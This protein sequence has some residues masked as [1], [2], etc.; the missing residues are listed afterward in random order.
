MPTTSPFANLARHLSA[1]KLSASAIDRNLKNRTTSN[2]NR[3]YTTYD[4]PKPA[5]ASAPAPGA[6]ASVV[7]PIYASAFVAPVPES[8]NDGH[9]EQKPVVAEAQVAKNPVNAFEG[10]GRT[11]TPNPMKAYARQPQA[12]TDALAAQ[13]KLIAL[14]EAAKKAAS[15]PSTQPVAG[16]VVKRGMFSIPAN[17]DDNDFTDDGPYDSDD[18]VS[19]PSSASIII[20]GSAKKFDYT[21]EQSAV[22]ECD[23]RLIVVDALAG[24]GKTTTAEGYA[25]AR[26]KERILYM[27]LNA[28]NAKEARSRFGSHVTVAT[29]HSVAWRAM[30]PKKERI[31]RNWKPIVLMDQLNLNTP[32]QGMITMR[33]LAD[34]FNSDDTYIS[35]KHA[36][37]VAYERDLRESDINNGIAHASLAWKRMCDPSDKMQMPDDAYLKMFALKAPKLN[38]DTIIF[39]EAQDANPV[40]LQI[41]K[42]QPHSKLLCIGDRHQSIYQFRGAVNAIEELSL[43]ST[44]LYLSNTWRFGP[45]VA[46]M[47]NL[48]LGELKNEKVKIKGMGTD[49][50][51]NGNHIT[52]LSRTNAEL[53]RLAAPIHGE[54]VHWVGGVDSYKMEQ[55][56]DAYHLFIREKD[57]IK[58]QLMRRKFNSWDEYSR[59]A[60]DANDGEAK[61]LVKVV[62][63]FTTDIPQVIADIR[64]NAVP[65]S[66]DASLTLTTAHRAKGM[67][68]DCV[69]ICND[70]ELLEESE[71][72]LAD[73]KNTAADLPIQDINLLY[74]AVTRACKSIELN[75]E[76]TKWIADLPRHRAN[77]E[78]AATRQ[79]GAVN[80]QVENM[81]RAE[82]M[83]IPEQ[84]RAERDC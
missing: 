67:E 65:T 22:I 7:L 49:G 62:E 2:A 64:K 80:D 75:D 21:D 48:I 26:P 6:P 4:A 68:W 60:N 12:K 1:S 41:V 19:S 72:A 81:L 55:V 13:A 59:Y 47:A 45:K 33:I 69:R 51:W 52:T 24:C 46:D 16:A 73:G 32:R 74:V 78:A 54:G 58:D 15:A 23:D 57:L 53:F 84:H 43:G 5:S 9:A 36:R 14:S 18:V 66:K 83:L 37:A 25:S 35:E 11:T 42:G 40:T 50:P 8:A 82:N 61:V 79:I 44:H 71:T 76:T 10:L 31:T 38:Y 27:C 20:G 29:T 39:D 77:R 28:P 17:T 3:S 30:N 70:F 56:M 34:F 63:E